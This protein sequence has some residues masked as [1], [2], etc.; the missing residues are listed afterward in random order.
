MYYMI[1]RKKNYARSLMVKSEFVPE[2]NYSIR[3]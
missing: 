3:R 2:F 1:G